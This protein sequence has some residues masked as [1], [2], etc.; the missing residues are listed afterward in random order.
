M[1]LPNIRFALPKDIPRILE[2]CQAHAAYEQSTYSLEGKVQQLSDALFHYPP[3]AYCL[4][5]EIDQQIV[6]YA[7]FMKQFSTWDAAFYL[8]LD[9]LYFEPEARGKG[10]G[11][12]VM[13]TIWA[14]A[15]AENC[16]QIQW[17]TPDFN[18][19][20]IGFYKKIGATA[21]SKERFFWLVDNETSST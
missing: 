8:Y 17:Q 7:T 15:K 4:L 6:G 2:L 20:A 16:F 21:K 1:K 10:L 19:S 13:D 18:E 12:L 14:F 5:L 9:C 3:A 11:K